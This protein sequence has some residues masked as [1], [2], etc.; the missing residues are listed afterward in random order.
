MSQLIGIFAGAVVLLHSCLAVDADKC[1]AM[2]PNI[3]FVFTDDQDLHL[4]SLDYMSSVKN[5]LAAKGT[6]FSNH[7]ATVSQCCPS[8]ASLLR[9]QHAHNTN[10]T[11]VSAPG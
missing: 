3:I 1:T 8:R 9:G 4:G 11:F 6:T 5:E 7:F 2:R 10:N